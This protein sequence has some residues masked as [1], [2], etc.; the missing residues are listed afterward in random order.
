M[1]Q[2]VIHAAQHAL[3]RSRHWRHDLV[4]SGC[5]AH[6]LAPDPSQ[7]DADTTFELA[8][9]SLPQYTMKQP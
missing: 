2:G 7:N 1:K 9:M 4:Q 8:E 5:K 3:N 6:L